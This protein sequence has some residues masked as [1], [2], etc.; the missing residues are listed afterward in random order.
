MVVLVVHKELKYKV[1]KLKNKKSE[2]MQARNK[3]KSELPVGEETIMD[4]STRSFT[5]M[6]D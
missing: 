3:N 6:I 1:E 5:V 4:Q 2:V